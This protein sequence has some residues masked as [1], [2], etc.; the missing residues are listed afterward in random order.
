[1]KA[2]VTQ[3]IHET[4]SQALPGAGHALR[5]LIA[6]NLFNYIDRQV[7]AAVVPQIKQSFF[8]EG[9]SVSGGTLAVIVEWGQRHLGFKPENALVGLL[10]MAF[11][12]FYMLGAPVF[13]RL[14]GRFSR[15]VLIAVG[16]IAWSLASGGSGL[17]TSFLMLLAT[18]CLVGIG[19]AAYGPIAPAVISDYY[20]V[21]IRGQVMAWF[22]MAIPVGSALG[23]VIGEQVASSGIGA[24]G[25]AHFGGSAESWR[26]AFYLVV[27]PGILLGIWSLF[28]RD[29]PSGQADH[30]A[31]TTDRRALQLRELRI[32]IRTPSYVFCT[33]GMCAMTFAIGGVAFWMPYYLASLPGAGRS[34]T[35]L[36]GVL[37]VVAGL[38][39]TLL[40]GIAGDRLRR[41]YPGSYFLVSGMAM[42]A[43]FPCFLAVLWAPFPAA[44]ILLFL[45]VFCLF[46]NTG[47][48]NTVLAN[49]TH[50]AMRSSAFAL[51][52]LFIH[53][54]GDVISPTLI[55]IFSDRYGMRSAFVGVSVFFLLAAGCWL[56]GAR[57]LQKDTEMAPRRL[58]PSTT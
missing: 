46:F 29:P 48:T 13:G 5:L 14:G 43:G 30:G 28:L 52:I 20:P 44:W 51:N 6:I 40:G 25:A 32:L 31:E 4:S 36:F 24:W 39:A 41:R 27:P 33:L 11:M 8:G 56:L 16:V 38:V 54:L 9:G 18:R 15:W 12:V 19:E 58:N 55:G 1:M 34:P 2:P 17:A 53:A 7:L 37:T 45:A 57:H 49:V 23:Y 35:T 47:P 22:Y 21:R 50:P 10:S 26:W 42:L 3:A